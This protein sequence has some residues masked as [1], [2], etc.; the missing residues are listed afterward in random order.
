[1]PIVIPLL[2]HCVPDIAADLSGMVRPNSI[3]FTA[4]HVMQT[5]YCDENSVCLSVCPSVCLSVCLSVTRVYCDKTVE[6]SVHIY[7]PYERTFILV[8]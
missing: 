4:L 6:R 8:F 3:I 2:Y 7:I 1:M 5:R